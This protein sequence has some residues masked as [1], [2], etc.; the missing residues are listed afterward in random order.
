MIT[1]SKPENWMELPMF[2]KISYY[3]T[4][5]TKEYA[6]YV[7]KLYAKH[8]VKEICGDD[9]QVA[10]VVRILKSYDDLTENDLN[11]NYIIKSSHGSGWNIYNDAS[12]PITLNEA[13]NKLRSWNRNYNP[14]EKQYSFIEPKFFIEEK[15]CDSILGYTGHACVYM[16]RCIHSN[17]ISIGVKYKNT[18]NSY[19]INWNL[20]QKP[21]IPFQIPKPR[22]LSKLL[23]LCKILSSN[24]EFVRL[25]FYIGENDVIY[26]SEFTFTPAGGR[27]VFDIQT[28]MNQGILWKK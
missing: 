3:G 21:K 19:D 20:T 17:P 6:E 25:D 5:L 26:F 18:Q 12:T 15:I 9:I 28:E 10:K 23:N 8:K 14:V 4:T 27:Q 13:I 2:K 16:F 1:F 11:K 22:C 24:F 7:D